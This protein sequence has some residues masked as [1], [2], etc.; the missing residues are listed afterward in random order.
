M[1]IALV[2]HVVIYWFASILQCS[3]KKVLIN[4]GREAGTTDDKFIT[5]KRSG[6]RLRRVCFPCP[7]VS[8]A[9]Y[10]RSSQCSCECNLEQGKMATLGYFSSRWQC[11]KN[12]NL[13][14]SQSKC[15]H[16]NESWRFL[17]SAWPSE[18]NNTLL[19]FSSAEI[20]F[21][22]FTRKSFKR[23]YMQYRQDLSFKNLTDLTH[24][25]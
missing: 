22:L 16:F 3:S 20:P 11:V 23:Y 10:S 15:F 14:E 17:V 1:H 18:Q 8:N 19:N 5:L 6:P 24:Y 7:V 25:S 13:R 12:S 21:R 9:G 4:I 2:I